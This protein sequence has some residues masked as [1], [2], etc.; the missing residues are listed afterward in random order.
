M[1]MFVN[2]DNSAF[3]GTVSSEIY[4][5][6]TMLL[7][8]TNKVLGTEQRYI[9]NS[10]PRRFG[11]SFAAK[12]LPFKHISVYEAAFYLQLHKLFNHT[13]MTLFFVKIYSN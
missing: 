4:V 12:M 10:R 8:Y 7:T 3:Q 11:K 2:P 6:K 5:D 13:C 9:C 1:G